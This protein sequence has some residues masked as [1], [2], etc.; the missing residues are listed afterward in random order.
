V[1]AAILRWRDWAYAQIE[2][3]PL[4]RA[5]HVHIVRWRAEFA[6]WQSR[7]ARRTRRWRA[8]IRLERMRRRGQDTS[9]N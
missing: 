4:W 2:A 3:H 7:F 1:R 8:A 9:S 5:L 6:V